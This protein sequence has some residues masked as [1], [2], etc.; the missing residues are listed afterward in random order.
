[1]RVYY[2]DSVAHPT[3][4]IM[5]P[6]AGD[7]IIDVVAISV[8]AASAGTVEEIQV[9]AYYEGVDTDGDGMFT[10]WHRE[11]FRDPSATDDFHR[12]HRG[13]DDR[14]ALRHELGRVLDPGPGARAR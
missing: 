10:E 12:R 1:M 14:R 3:G 5:S 8:D 6:A 4:S 11:Y 2:D 9:L 13:H 7:T